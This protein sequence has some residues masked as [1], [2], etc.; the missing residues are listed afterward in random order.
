[1]DVAPCKECME[2]YPACHD[3]CEKYGK[4]KQELDARRNTIYTA[5]RKEW[6]VSIFKRD[7]ITK[8][9]KSHGKY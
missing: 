5:A 6:Q 1:M 4:W 2:R 8:M 3:R 7:I 9:K